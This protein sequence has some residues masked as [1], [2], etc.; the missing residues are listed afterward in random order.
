MKYLESSTYVVGCARCYVRTTFPR[1]RDYPSYADNLRCLTEDREA[2][3]LV[4]QRAAPI[5]T[6]ALRDRWPIVFP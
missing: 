4:W 1:V 5:T 3:Y 6:A 2:R